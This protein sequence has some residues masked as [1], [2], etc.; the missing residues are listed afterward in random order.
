VADVFEGIRQQGVPIPNPVDNDPAN[1]GRTVPCPDCVNGEIECT[2]GTGKR[3]CPTCQGAKT[4]LCSHCGGTGKVVRSRE[5][6]RSFD[7]RTQVRFA[8]SISI[9]EGQLLKANG[10]LI[11]ENEVDETIYAD[12]IPEGV[13]MDVWQQAVQLVKNAAGLG[14]DKAGPHGSAQASS[15]PTLQVLELIRIPFT[16]VR[17]G[18]GN[19]DYT[20][21]IYDGPGSEKFYAERYPARWDR[22]ERLVRSITSDLTAPSDENA[23]AGN[24]SSQARGYRVPVEKPPYTITEVD[25]EDTAENRWNPGTQS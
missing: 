9:P 12:A 19:S 3:V 11:Y 22:I 24:A 10:E 13:P 6:V 21:Y 2:C 15:R 17:Y 7:L 18:Y 25:T 5:I 20:I 23:Q 1:K 4:D 16:E 14:S 8:G